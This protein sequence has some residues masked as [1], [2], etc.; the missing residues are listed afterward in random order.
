MKQLVFA[1][2]LFALTACDHFQNDNWQSHFQTIDV[3]VTGGESDEGGNSPFGGAFGDDF[4]YNVS[5]SKQYWG[6]DGGKVNSHY[7]KYKVG[8]GSQYYR[9][10]TDAGEYA[11]QGY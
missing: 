8:G 9:G 4:H 5:S 2:S 11:D 6:E 7:T 1:L 3:G 10:S